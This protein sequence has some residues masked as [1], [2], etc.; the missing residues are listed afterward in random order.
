MILIKP[1]HFMDIIKLYGAGIEVFV[2]DTDYG[3]D[4]YRAANQI[5]GD[6]ETELKLTV[7]ADDICGPCQYL[8]QGLCGDHIGHIEGVTSKDQYNKMLDGRILKA[9]GMSE[10][11]IC[12]AGELCE[13]L[14]QFTGIVELVWTKEENEARNRR[15]TLFK[16]GAGKYLRG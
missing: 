9:L 8:E 5:V 6:R 13:R 2:P 15:E 16:A 10:G 12:T 4:F 3:H 14:D 1:H 7:N 11:E